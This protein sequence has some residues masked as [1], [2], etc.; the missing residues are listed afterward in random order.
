M[1]AFG[2]IAGVAVVAAVV[3]WRTRNVLYTIVAGMGTLWALTAGF[4]L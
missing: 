1:K 2:I 4:G 3:A